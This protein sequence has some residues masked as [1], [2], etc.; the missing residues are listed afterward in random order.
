ML[1]FAAVHS[2]GIDWCCDFWRPLGFPVPFRLMEKQHTLG[3]GVFSLCSTA[4]V[5]TNP[6]RGVVCTHLHP[7]YISPFNLSLGVDMGVLWDTE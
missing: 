7:T 2:L 4:V 1:L 6:A 5:S 3:R